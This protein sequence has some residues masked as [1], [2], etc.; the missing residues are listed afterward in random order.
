MLTGQEMQLGRG[1]T[2]ADTARVLSRYV[3]AIMI[4]TLDHDTADGAGA[5]RDRAGDQRPDQALASLPGDGRRD[6][7]RGASRADP[8]QAPS[9]GPATP[10]TCWPP[11]CTR[12]SASTS[13]CDVATPPELEA[14]EMAARLGRRAP[15]PPIHARQRSGRGGRGRRLRRH[16]HLGVDGRRG[17]RA[18]PQP[19]QAL[20]GQ[21]AAD[22]ARP[23]RTP[24]SCIACRR[25]AARRSPTR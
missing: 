1:E 22:G 24:S 6:D 4:R 16:R 2:I 8:R 3:D 11:G 13:G 20:S 25:I 9:P 7:L 17:R 14:E 5:A 23:S 19:A 21:C 15:A 12:P 18:P 10:T